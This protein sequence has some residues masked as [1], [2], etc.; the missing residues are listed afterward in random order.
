LPNVLPLWSAPG[1]LI[2]GEAYFESLY[3]PLLL[4]YFESLNPPLLAYV[5][6]E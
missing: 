2:E 4:A 3:P 1:S 6:P 5:L